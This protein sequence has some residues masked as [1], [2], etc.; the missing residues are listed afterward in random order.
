MLKNLQEYALIAEIFSAL[1]VVAS[2]VFVGFQIQQGAEET[3]LNTRAIESNAYQNLVAQIGELNSLVIQNPE[4]ADLRSRMFEGETNASAG[5][6]AQFNAYIT[7]MVRHG[8]LAF[9]Q[10]E[11]GLIDEGSLFSVLAP[12]RVMLPLEASQAWWEFLKPG[13]DP[14]YVE[15]IATMLSVDP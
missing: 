15:Y 5:E 10:Y 2:L 4:F 11:S 1:A 12:L 6:L 8:D 13:F 3:A 9:R 14:D 7:M